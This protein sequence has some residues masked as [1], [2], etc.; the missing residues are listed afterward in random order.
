MWEKMSGYLVGVSWPSSF[1]WALPTAECSH[2]A[3]HF[4]MER[5]TEPMSVFSASGGATPIAVGG[6]P[7]RNRPRRNFA[8]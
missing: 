1:S 8:I 2:P 4:R 6:S 3:F 7:N 5:S